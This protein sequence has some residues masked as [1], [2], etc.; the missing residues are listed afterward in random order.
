MM[1]IMLTRT[2][3]LSPG[4]MVDCNLY[5]EAGEPTAPVTVIC[6]PTGNLT[7]SS[8]GTY[9]LDT[10]SG[11]NAGSQLLLINTLTISGATGANGSRVQ[12]AA[13]SGAP[14]PDF[15][16][17]GDFHYGGYPGSPATGNNGGPGGPTINAQFRLS[18]KNTGTIS[19]GVGGIAGGGGGGGGGSGTGGGNGGSQGKSGGAGGSAGQSSNGYILAQ[20]GTSGSPTGQAGPNWVGT[21]SNGYAPGG[22]GAGGW[23]GGG[24]GGPGGNG[25]TNGGPGGAGAFRSPGAPG[26]IYSGTYNLV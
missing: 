12:G 19:G 6:K 26:A 4:A 8:T 14:Y 22:G 9:A 16:T 5:T 24:N 25:F 2:I 11:W 7:A 1:P 3:V 23:V 17:E 15:T 20:P 10:G 21:S 13:G 18:I